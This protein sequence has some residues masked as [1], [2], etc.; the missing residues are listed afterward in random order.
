VL[1]KEKAGRAEPKH[2]KRSDALR[3]LAEIADPLFPQDKTGNDLI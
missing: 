2:R 1:E 3:E